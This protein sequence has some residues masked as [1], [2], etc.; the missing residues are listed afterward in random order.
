[1]AICT[2]G[3]STRPP[4][5]ARS[6]ITAI[7]SWCRRRSRARSCRSRVDR[8]KPSPSPVRARNRTTSTTCAT[9]TRLRLSYHLTED[10][11]V[12]A[13]GGGVLKNPTN[14]HADLHQF[15]RPMPV[16]AFDGYKVAQVACGDFN[17]VGLTGEPLTSYFPSLLAVPK[18]TFVESRQ[19][20]LIRTVHGEVV[21]A[22]DLDYFKK[23]RK[24][25]ASRGYGW[26]GS[27]HAPRA[28]THFVWS[29]IARAAPR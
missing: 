5:R 8:T 17:V 26:G 24:N 18:L 14:G 9:R 28:R 6:V 22:H 10:H 21:I 12:W 19:C 11:R 20:G 23:S 15:H 3:A 7:R 13:W 25:T 2:C 29:H 16:E 4:S 27:V 1:M